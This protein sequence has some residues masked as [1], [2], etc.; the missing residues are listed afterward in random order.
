LSWDTLGER[1][2]WSGSSPSALK[3][4]RDLTDTP[5]HRTQRQK[6]F[7]FMPNQLNQIPIS[8]RLWFATIG[9]IASDGVLLSIFLLMAVNDHHRIEFRDYVFFFVLYAIG[10][11]VGWVLI[12]IPV[13]IV[14]PARL[15]KHRLWPVVSFVIGAGLGPLAL[16]P[17][18]VVWS[19]YTSRGRGHFNFGPI[20]KDLWVFSILVSTVSFLVYAAL[21]RKRL[22]EQEDDREAV[23]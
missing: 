7:L 23:A 9:I 5:G 11:I 16:L 12:G 21:L 2:N 10:S 19:L 4:G 3:G 6:P 13:A 1:R 18:F 17:V 8:T 14:F 22:L 20:T 15:L